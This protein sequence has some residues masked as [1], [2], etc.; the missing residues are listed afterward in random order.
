MKNQT[1]RYP[2]CSYC[3]SDE[4]KFDAYSIWDKENQEYKVDQTFDEVYCEKCEGETSVNWLNIT[5]L[6]ND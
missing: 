2:V 5:E 3:G 1:I 4:I 6:N